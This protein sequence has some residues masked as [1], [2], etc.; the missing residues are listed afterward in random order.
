M[1]FKYELRMKATMPNGFKKHIVE[2]DKGKFDGIKKGEEKVISK[3][4]IIGKTEE[5]KCFIKV[6]TGW[7]KYIE[8]DK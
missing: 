1:K 8:V 5:G 7:E 4:E 2:K 6:L 3:D